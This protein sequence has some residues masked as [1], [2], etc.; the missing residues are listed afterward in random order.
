MKDHIVAHARISAEEMA[1]PRR[2]L[3]ADGKIKDEDYRNSSSI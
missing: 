2:M 1:W 3:F